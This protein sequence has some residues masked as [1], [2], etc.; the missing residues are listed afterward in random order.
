MKQVLPFAIYDTNDTELPTVQE[1]GDALENYK[2]IPSDF[3]GRI[4]STL[5]SVKKHGSHRL[6]VTILSEPPKGRRC[7][8]SRLDDGYRIERGKLYGTQLIDICPYADKC[9]CGK[10]D[11]RVAVD[12]HS[13]FKS[14]RGMCKKGGDT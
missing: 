6:I 5:Q 8:H 4:W 2:P 10:T 3:I 9:H 13:R 11:T 1:I 7:I 12:I 14:D